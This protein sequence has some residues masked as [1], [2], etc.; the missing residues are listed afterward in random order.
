MKNFN[1]IH[2]FP[3]LFF[4]P[5]ILTHPHSENNITIKKHFEVKKKSDSLT[6]DVSLTNHGGEEKITST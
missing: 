3:H 6:L 4:I 2:F 5:H 1:D